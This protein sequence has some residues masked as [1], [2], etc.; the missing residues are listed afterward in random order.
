MGTK[1]VHEKMTMYVV[2]WEKEQQIAY[3][4]GSAC[5]QKECVCVAILEADLISRI[6]GCDLG[7]ITC[8]SESISF[9]SGLEILT[10]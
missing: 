8:H 6:G 3:L 2:K 5:R 7:Q 10:S 4:R 9:S 1:E